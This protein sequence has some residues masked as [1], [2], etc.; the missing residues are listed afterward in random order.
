MV[1]INYF[2]MNLHTAGSI[3]GGN[4][5]YH[6]VVSSGELYIKELKIEAGD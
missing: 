3:V 6:P 5:F 1:F 4:N 2:V